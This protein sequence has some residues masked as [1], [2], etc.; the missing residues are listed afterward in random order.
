MLKILRTF[1]RGAA[2]ELTDFASESDGNT[3]TEALEIFHVHIHF[4]A[5]VAS[6]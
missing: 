4:Y 1:E 5:K 3:E 2:F 6:H